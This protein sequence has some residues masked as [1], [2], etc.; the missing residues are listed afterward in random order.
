MPHTRRCDFIAKLVLA[1]IMTA[2]TT[3]AAA[4]RKDIPD[5]FKWNLGDLYPNEAAWTKA[6][7]DLKQRIPTLAKHRGHLGDSAGTLLTALEAMFVLDRDLSRLVV[8]ASSLSDQDTRAA[9][10]REMKQSAEQLI[11]ELSS[12]SAWVRPEILTLD[13]AKVH[14]FAAG[15]P[16]L[17]PYRMFLDET[18]RRKAHTLPAGEEK[19]AA[20]AGEMAK[21]GDEVFGILSN[22]DLPYPTVKLSTG[23]DVRLDPAAYSLH[24]QA[25]AR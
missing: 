18:L 20:E 1:F 2:V 17:A 15:E 7:D 8:Y 19:V 3:A 6:R 22:A 12:A 11:T 5:K 23:E 16:R 24:R 10:P 9:R 4:D 13:P 14:V 21:A 25:R